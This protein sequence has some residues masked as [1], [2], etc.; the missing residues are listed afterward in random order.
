MSQRIHQLLIF[1]SLIALMLTV[2]SPAYA[3]LPVSM[4]AI[5][6]LGA[7]AEPDGAVRVTMTVSVTDAEGQV[8]TGLTA[9]DFSVVENAT[10]IEPQQVSVAVSDVPLDVALLLDTSSQSAQPG[11]TGVRAIDS[12]KDAAIGL[13]E[14]LADGDQIAV[15]EFNG[16][17][18]LEQEL[19][20]DHNL[21]IDQGVVKLDAL[22]S[23]EVCLYDVLLQALERM[24]ED[25]N[26]R[27]AIVVYTGSSDGVG[28]SACSGMV[29]DDVVERLDADT[30]IVPIY[31][32]AYGTA[33]NAEALTRLA[34]GS[35]G[36]SAVGS[37]PTLLAELTARILA[38]LQNQYEITY[39]SQAPDSLSQVAL[40]ENRSQQSDRRRVVIPPAIE[41]TPTPVP[42]FSLGLTVNQPSGSQ[43]EVLLEVPA[44]VTLAKTE[45]FINEQLAQ[46]AVEPPFDRFE[47]DILELG[48]GQHS[49][50]AEATDVNGTLATSQVELTLTIPPTPVPTVAPTP[51]PTATPEASLLSALTTDDGLSTLA[52]VLIGAGFLILMILLSVIAYLL[53]AQSRQPAVGAGQPAPEPHSRPV[54]SQETMFDIE[55][56]ASP[57]SGPETL[58][59]MEVATPVVR[60]SN[61]AADKMALG[62]AKLVVIAGQPILNQAEYVLS[63]PEIK[64]GRNSAGKVLNDIEIK[65]REVSRSHAKITYRNQEFFIQ[66]SQSSTGTKVNGVKLSSFQ[67]A[68][69]KPGMEIEIG[70]HVKFRL[71]VIDSNR[72]ELD[73]ELGN[74]WSGDAADADRT[75]F[76]QK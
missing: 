6:H 4:V 28:T 37:D 18:Q 15:Y 32:V 11:P 65:D 41:P 40:T 64:I 21:A 51:E 36:Y 45:L 69:L 12:M 52:I 54:G 48:S 14:G 50:R 66:D 43:L 34:Q 74:Q 20:Y 1:S 67:D 9:A 53:F 63:K 60:P 38:L 42:Q 24:A 22:G 61:G 73:F 46:R 30:R 56:E 39:S 26:R 19:T 59:D 33:I 57:G 29:A 62:R 3:Q 72:T 7:T 16:Q 25:E 70:P 58:L 44:E 8:V 35:G 10:P 27:R 55:M 31:S 47:V 49:L 75:L 13:I 23:P 76:E 5:T 71:E 68:A 2:S 17:L